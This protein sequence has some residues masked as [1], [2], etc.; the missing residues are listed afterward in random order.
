M[1]RAQIA[2]ALSA[3]IPQRRNILRERDKQDTRRPCEALET[4]MDG[5]HGRI[6]GEGRHKFDRDGRVRAKKLL[7]YKVLLQMD[8]SRVNDRADAYIIPFSLKL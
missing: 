4:P 5:S 7:I 2:E 1:C 6:F 8:S 3:V